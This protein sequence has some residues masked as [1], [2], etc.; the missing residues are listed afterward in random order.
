M[1]RF[2]RSVPVPPVRW[3]HL[4]GVLCR[5]KMFNFPQKFEGFRSN[6]DLCYLILLSLF[7]HTIIFM[8]LLDAAH[9]HFVFSLDGLILVVPFI[10]HFGCDRTGAD[11][12]GVAI[13][14]AIFIIH[15]IQ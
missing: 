12:S 15:S 13:G 4:T 2:D 7:F 1:A 6:H 9:Y 11:L 5:R 8:A 3:I 10:D 14:A